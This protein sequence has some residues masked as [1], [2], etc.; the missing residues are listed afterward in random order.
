MVRSAF[1]KPSAASSSPVRTPQT[2]GVF[3]PS[4]DYEQSRRPYGLSDL[5]QALPGQLFTPEGLFVQPTTATST[6][7]AVDDSSEDSSDSEEDI[8]GDNREGVNAGSA[9]AKQ[10]QKKERQWR[11]WSEETIPAMLEP[12]LELLRVTDSLRD[13]DHVRSKQGCTGCPGNRI[14]EVSCIYFDSMS[15]MTA[16]QL[17]LIILTEIIKLSL[18]AC[19]D[20]ALQLLQLGLFP[21]APIYPTLAVDLNMLDFARGLFVNAAPNITAW[22]ETLEGFLSA[23]KFKLTTRVSHLFTVCGLLLIILGIQDSLRGR[24]GAALHWYAVLV[25]TKNLC[26]RKYLTYIHDNFVQ[27]MD[28]YL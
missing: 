21:C 26:L 12:Y 7:I 15:A 23:R 22:C 13:L 11:K 27:G 20:V 19:T 1:R 3:I 8:E 28:I 9:Y 14:I 18:C 17:S 4:Q 2:P 24:F 10:Q 16:L 25:D 6:P 5:I